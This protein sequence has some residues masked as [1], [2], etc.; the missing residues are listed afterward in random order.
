MRDLKEVRPGFL[1]CV[2]RLWQKIYDEMQRTVQRAGYVKQKLFEWAVSV[3]DQVR[4]LRNSEQPIPLWLRTKWTL[5]QSLV[6][7]K[8]KAALGLDRAIMLGS[9]AGPLSPTVARFFGCLDLDIFEVYGSS[10]T[11]GICSGNIPGKVR[12]G[13]VGVPLLGVHLR[14]GANGEV[15]VSGPNVAMGY[16]GD[17]RATADAFRNGWLQF[18][19]F[20][21]IFIISF[22]Y[23]LAVKSALEMWVNGIKMDGER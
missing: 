21:Y 19:V 5:A 13:T 20:V 22:L 15:L 12:P 4:V 9:G 2:P 8:V 3:G 10:E 17:E 7:N 23:S 6:V 16:Y 11:T 1:T 18:S 14:L